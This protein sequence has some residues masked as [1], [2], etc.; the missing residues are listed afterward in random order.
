M[1]CGVLHQTHWNRA[2]EVRFVWKKVTCTALGPQGRSVT[3]KCRT[4]A[5]LC[6]ECRMRA[7]AWLIFSID[8]KLPLTECAK[9]KLVGAFY[10]FIHTLDMKDDIYDFILPTLA[11][12]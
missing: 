9:R 4:T 2:L 8:S 6:D 5:A 12:Q 10:C 7:S 1:H 3:K 11:G